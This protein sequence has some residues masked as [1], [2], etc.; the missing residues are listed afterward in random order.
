VT[1]IV[2]GSC[3]IW[4]SLWLVIKPGLRHRGDRGGK[5]PVPCSIFMSTIDLQPEEPLVK[6]SRIIAAF[7]L[8]LFAVA[9]AEA[10]TL[11]QYR[12]KQ[13]DALVYTTTLKT[14]STMS[15]MPGGA[16][17]TFA[18]TMTQ[19]IKLLAAAI[20]PDG[21]V[22]LHQSVEAVSVE[23]STPMGK[24]AYDSGD[25]ASAER[26]EG[27]QALGRVFGA[28]VGSTIS[29]I[30]APSGAIQRIEGVQKAYDKIIQE[31]PKDRS[32]TQMAE[33]L[34][35]VLSD[36]AIRAAL[37][38]SFPRMPPQPVKPGDTWTAQISLGSDAT[39]RISGT[40]T[41]TLKQIDGAGAPG[42]ATI[43]VALTLKQETTPPV[44]PAGMTMKIGDSRGTGEIEFDVTNGRIRTSTMK[45][46]MPAT[47]TAPGRDGRPANMKS[48]TT[49]SMKMELV[50]K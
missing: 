3:L 45:T 30:M 43:G 4:S 47:M 12:W 46:E 48:T 1:L 35:S 25:P 28:M 36:A 6:A 33:S 16:D 2:C 40:Q 34:K 24:I 29:V 21:T 15:A 41:M 31:L 32:A 49:T 7:V 18:Q 17:A 8:A 11:L 20:A 19:R 23:M 9:S 26:D 10:Q 27:A 42:I 5:R 38:Q 37:E 13:G 39:G 14:D 22:T 50:G 44:G